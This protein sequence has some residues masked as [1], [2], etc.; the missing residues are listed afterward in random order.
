MWRAEVAGQ[1][2]E[3]LL[4]EFCARTSNLRDHAAFYAVATDVIAEATAQDADRADRDEN[5]RHWRDRLPA[6]AEVLL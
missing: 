3:Q 2:A 6:L 4:E 1:V 5:A